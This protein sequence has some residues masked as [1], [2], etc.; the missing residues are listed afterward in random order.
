MISSSDHF[1]PT[2][3]LT[4]TGTV[5]IDGA[6]FTALTN[7]ESEVASGIYKVNLAAADLNGD[8]VTL[9]FTASGADDRLITIKT[10]T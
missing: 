7:A 5:S 8:V 4:I 1:T 10:D 3:G 6:A 9:R 2:T